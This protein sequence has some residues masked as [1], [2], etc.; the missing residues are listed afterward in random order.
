MPARFQ[1]KLLP[2]TEDNQP[3]RDPDAQPS[4]QLLSE[5][6]DGH[7]AWG[8]GKNFVLKHKKISSGTEVEGQNIEYVRQKLEEDEFSSCTLPTIHLEWREGDDHYA[9]QR[10]LEGEPLRVALPNLG[11]QDLVRISKQLSHYITRLKALTFDYMA[12]MDGQVVTDE[13]LL[14]PLPEGT[15]GF[16]R[17]CTTD[18]DL[19][20]ML[21]YSISHRL[22][23][24][25]YEAFMSKMPTALPFTFSHADIH[26]DNIMVKDGEFVG[27]IN[28]ELAG[29]YPSWWEYVN[30][31]PLLSDHFSFEVKNHPAL[32]W[33]RV[34]HMIREE[35]ASEA[36][37]R[38][39]EYLQGRPWGGPV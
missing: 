20:K 19:R 9:I 37:L 32:N 38:L 2:A 27:L 29:F 3:D 7:D 25:V 34:Y 15:T 26:E 30:A 23:E 18:E 14:R 12:R 24:D 22:D 1:F 39:K 17:P 31:S 8:L 21:G 11:A 35:D 16:Y 6:P 36:E 5:K 4:C 28:W 33:F 10:R 13:R